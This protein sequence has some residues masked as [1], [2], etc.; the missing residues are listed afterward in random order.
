MVPY[1]KSVIII[2][3]LLFV[4]A[5][6][7]LSLPQYTSDIIDVGIIGNGVEHIFPEAITEEEFA[8]AELFM[9]EEEKEIWEDSYTK[10]DGNYELKKLEKED[11]DIVNIG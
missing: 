7:D 4:Q 5:W 3:L 8:T 2:V 6:C 11:F 9:T 10:A 1:W